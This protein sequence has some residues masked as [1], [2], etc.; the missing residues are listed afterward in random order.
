[1]G[2]VKIQEKRKE[3][4]RG[5]EK[6]KEAILV[7]SVSGFLLPSHFLEQQIPFLAPSHG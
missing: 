5:K 4:R 7:G 2:K 6:R 1:M 3:E